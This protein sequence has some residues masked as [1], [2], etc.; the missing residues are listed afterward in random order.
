MQQEKPK[1]LSRE[2]L[3]KITAAQ[4]GITMTEA[5]AVIDF[6]ECIGVIPLDA[7]QDEAQSA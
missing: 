5:L 7:I 3:K 1:K 4:C 6:L 2:T